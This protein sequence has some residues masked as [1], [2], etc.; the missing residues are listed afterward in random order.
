[1]EAAHMNMKELNKYA[2]LKGLNLGQAEKDYYQNLILFIIYNKISKELIFKGGTALAKCYGLNR[3]SEDLDF[4]VAEKKDYIPILE[5]GLKQFGLSYSIKNVM[6]AGDSEKYKIKIEGPLYR[7]SIK[8]LCS[9]TLDFSLR[10]KVILNPLIKTIGYHMDIIPV[11]EVY[12]LREEEIL[13]EKI[14]AIMMRRSARDVYDAVFLLRKGAKPEIKIVNKKLALA[15]LEFD[16]KQFLLKCRALKGIWQ[17]E[18][19]SLVKNVPEFNSYMKEIKHL[20]NI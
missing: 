16:K 11:F 8:T 4:T 10:E 5:N 19:S 6:R 20:V 13:A 14:R 17:S 7:D 1:M 2:E 9:V 3:F 18:L 15:N 12:V